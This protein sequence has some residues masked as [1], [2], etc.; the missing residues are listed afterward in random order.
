MDLSDARDDLLVAATAA[1]GALVL[2]VG[3]D[4]VAGVA[5]PTLL[6]LA[7]LAVYFVYLFTRKGGPYGTLDTHRNWMILVGVVTVGAA[8]YA[9][10]V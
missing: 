5:V 10:L 3:V 9:A 4:L 2:T 1:A 6:R 7:P 8:V